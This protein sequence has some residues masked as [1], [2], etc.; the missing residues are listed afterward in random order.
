MNLGTKMKVLALAFALAFAVQPAHAVLQV[1]IDIGG[2][3]VFT[4]ADGQACDTNPLIGVLQIGDMTIDGVVLNGSIQASTHGPDVL[5]TSSLII[6][7]T[8]PFA[9]SGEAVISDT[10]YFGNIH[11]IALSGAGTWALASGS[12][13]TN[14]WFADALNGQGGGP[15]LL[16][17][18]TLLDSFADTAVGAADSYSHDGLT[19]FSA[20]GPFSMTEQVDLT[21]TAGASLVNRG[22]TMTAVPEPPTWGLL[23]IGFAALGL[24]ALTRRNVR[25]EPKCRMSEGF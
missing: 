14:R 2:G 7:N 9:V 17:P 19:P 6:R 3:P 23:V 1:A 4:C 25:G 18:G 24:G 22:Q 21:L 16:T 12:T 15:G 20:S 13:T 5:N 10:D 8:N 11:E